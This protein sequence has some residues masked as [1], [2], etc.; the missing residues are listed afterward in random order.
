MQTNIN[1]ID[2]IKNLQTYMELKKNMIMESDNPSYKAYEE[3][4][5]VLVGKI[6]KNITF[7]CVRCNKNTMMGYK[8]CG[9]YSG[10]L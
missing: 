8:C 2:V 7:Q 5:E 6:L 9:V 4:R 10:L 1:V 3:I